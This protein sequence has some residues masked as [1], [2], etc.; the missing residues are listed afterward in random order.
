M[1]ALETRGTIVDGD[2]GVY[3][4]WGS[5]RRLSH[6]VSSH[7]IFRLKQAKARQKTYAAVLIRPFLSRLNV[8]GRAN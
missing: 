3:K 5:T 4:S 2:E 6:Q 8:P 1:G 7:K